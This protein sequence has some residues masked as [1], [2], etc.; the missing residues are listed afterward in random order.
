MSSFDPDYRS[1][2]SY[3]R[4]GLD[5]TACFAELDRRKVV[6]EKVDVAPGVMAPLRLPEGVG[7]VTYRTLLPR[8]QGRS[9]PWEVFDCRLALSL[10]DLSKILEAHGIDEVVMF[11]AWRPPAKSWPKD[12]LA[13]RHPGGLAIDIMRF[14]RDAPPPPDEPTAGAGGEAPAAS[15]ARGDGAAERQWLNVEHHF[16]GRIGDTTCGDGASPPTESTPEAVELRAIVCE[17]AA[18]RIFTSILTPNYNEPHY[19][20][21]HFDLAVDVKWRI[22]R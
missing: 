6:Y 17:V 15:A 8:E 9:S 19:N 2:P 3:V 7:G 4:A 12:K 21:F 13:V 16:H 11:S 14:G 18:A 1:A 22:V 10:V 20:H 5:A